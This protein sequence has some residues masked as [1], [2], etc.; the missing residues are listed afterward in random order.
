MSSLL[1]QTH[2]IIGDGIAG[3]GMVST[4]DHNTETFTDGRSVV[5]DVT[6]YGVVSDLYSIWNIYVRTGNPSAENRDTR[7]ISQ[8]GWT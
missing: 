3:S 6:G 2:I 8:F 7:D 4:L 5:L 1:L